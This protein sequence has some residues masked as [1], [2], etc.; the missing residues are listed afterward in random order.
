[1]NDK[2]KNLL[3]I[4]HPILQ[5]PMANVAGGKLAGAVSDAGGLGMIGVGYV[6]EEWLLEQFSLCDVS[7][8]GVGFLTWVLDKD[9]SLLDVAIKHKP[10]AIC[11][12]F[13][14]PQPYIQ[15]IQDAGIK[16]ICQVQSVKHAI[17]A[18]DNGV[19][20]IVAQGA[21]GGGHIARRGTFA[22]VPAVVDAASPLP[23]V[24]AGGIAD[25]RGFK[26]ALALGAQ[27]IMLGTRF[28]ASHEALGGDNAKEKLIKSSADSL[29]SNG[30]VDD[31]RSSP[32]PKPY[33]GKYLSNEFID[34]Y[35]SNVNTKAKQ[36]YNNSSD[37]AIKA[38]FA[39]EGIDLIN[40]VK[41]V[42]EIVDDLVN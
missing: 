20:I 36:E 7:K 14:N 9:P 23:V 5:A 27:G 25:R 18:K 10:K 21:D 3:A 16:V 6:K 19:D 22:L 29:Q 1:M 13:G 8:V 42:Q 34:N 31:L 2:L 41:S 4:Q 39:G 12:S 24:A 30:I 33:V 32:W 35:H 17:S 38:V 37:P 15:K 28:Y 40:K 26:A 11:L